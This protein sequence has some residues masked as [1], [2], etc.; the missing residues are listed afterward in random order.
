[1]RVILVKSKPLI[2]VLVVAVFGLSLP[3]GPAEAT[4]VPTEASVARAPDSETDRARV[5]ALLDREDVQAQLEAYGISVD[6][7]RARV[8][9]LTDDE[10]TRIAGK[11][12][13]LPAGGDPITGIAVLLTLVVVGVI[14]GIV[15]VFK[16]LTGAREQKA[17]A[18]KVE[19][20]RAE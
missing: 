6:E 5:R 15:W 9:S 10:V 20:Q 12:D 16:Q 13:R 18:P 8:D 14:K 4:L 11:L 19:E 3:Q 2:Y 7:A 17:E 1:M